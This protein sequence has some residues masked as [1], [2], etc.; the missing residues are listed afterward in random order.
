MVLV[1]ALNYIRWSMESV[2]ELNENGWAMNLVEGGGV[3]SSRVKC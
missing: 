2:D 1:D 3:G